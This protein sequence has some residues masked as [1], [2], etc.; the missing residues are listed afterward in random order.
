MLGTKL[1]SLQ[2][3]SVSAMFDF[4]ARI[5]AYSSNIDLIIWFGFD[6]Y[7]SISGVKKQNDPLA[8][9]MLR[10]E[11]QDTNTRKL[12]TLP[13]FYITLYDFDTGKNQNAVESM[14]IERDQVNSAQSLFAAN[15]YLGYFEVNASDVDSVRSFFKDAF[16]LRPMLSDDGLLALGKR[17]NNTSCFVGTC[18]V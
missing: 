6:L 1:T 4:C 8:S 13:L 14:C 17:L 5:G 12:V 7:D 16:P 2:S 18:V 9:P 15:E 11:F 10:L 3:T